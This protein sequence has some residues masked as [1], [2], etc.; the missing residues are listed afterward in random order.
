LQLAL[1][2]GRENLKSPAAC[3]FYGLLQLI[4]AMEDVLEADQTVGLIRELTAV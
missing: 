3:R 4:A 2:A 1:C